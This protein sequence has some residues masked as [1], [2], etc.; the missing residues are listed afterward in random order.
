V[1]AWGDTVPSQLPSTGVGGASGAFSPVQIAGLVVWYKADTGTYQDSVGGTPAA[2]DG[3]PVGAWADQSG[4]GHDMQQATASAR[5]VLKLG[6]Q[7]GNPVLR[8]DGVQ[9]W[10]RPAGFTINQ[11]HT[12]FVVMKI[13]SASDGSHVPVDGLSNVSGRMLGVGGGT[14]SLNAGAELDGPALDANWHIWRGTYNG[15][16]SK[17]SLDNGATTTGDAG[18]TNAGG[19]T[20]GVSGDAGAFA[21]CDVGEILE[22]NADLADADVAQVVHYLNQRWTIF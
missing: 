3:D 18:A 14:A 8:F 5:P 22:Y 11:P 7:N 6:V 16:G 21:D 9:T 10:I 17:I 13:R 12:R 20:V 4:N 19:I 2:A 1:T 15:A